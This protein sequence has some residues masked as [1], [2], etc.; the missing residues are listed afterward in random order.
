[1]NE[2]LLRIDNLS[3]DY[4]VRDGFLSAVKNASF[5]IRKK[6]IFAIVGESGCGKSTIA[7]SILRLLPEHKIGRAHV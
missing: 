2:E 7:H 4:K 3:V 6:E 5:E 1:M